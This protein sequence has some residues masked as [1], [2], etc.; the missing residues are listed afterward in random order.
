[1]FVFSVDKQNLWLKYLKA[2]TAMNAKTSL[3]VICIEAI[4]YLL[5]YNLY[6]CTFNSFTCPLVF[7]KKARVCAFN[8]QN[9]NFSLVLHSCCSCCTR[10]VRA[11]LALY[12]YH[13]C[14]N[15]VAR[16][17]NSG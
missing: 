2:R 1:M 10:V 6:D 14:R 9:E 3:F 4:I 5:L 16:R 12:S 15:R 13:S 11:A 8:L 7:L 17:V